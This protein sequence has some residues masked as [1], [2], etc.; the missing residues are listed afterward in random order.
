MVEVFFLIKN[1]SFREP[2]FCIFSP[3]CVL[4]RGWGWGKYGQSHLQPLNAV[5][6]NFILSPSFS[7][8]FAS[9]RLICIL[10]AFS[11]VSSRTPAALAVP[12][13]GGGVSRANR[14]TGGNSR[15]CRRHKMPIRRL[16]P[17]HPPAISAEVL[18]PKGVL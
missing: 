7:S 2:V 14:C 5:L 1:S 6:P 17:V 9:L 3:P 11:A 12:I 4:G 16:P 8:S 10:V 15:A 13:G 18:R